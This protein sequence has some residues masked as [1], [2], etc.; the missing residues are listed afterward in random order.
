MI[1][2]EAA[3]RAATDKIVG[4]RASPSELVEIRLARPEIATFSPDAQPLPD[5]YIPAQST[6]EHAEG[7][8]LA[9]IDAAVEQVLGSPMWPKPPPRLI[10]GETAVVGNSS[11]RAAGVT[12]S[13]RYCGGIAGF[14]N[15]PAWTSS[16][17]L[18]MSTSLRRWRTLEL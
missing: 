10:H 9:R 14:V 18:C 2:P 12:N 1:C 6:F 5:S 11:T 8:P 15:T 16:S 13:P 17:W 3:E 4:W 7:L